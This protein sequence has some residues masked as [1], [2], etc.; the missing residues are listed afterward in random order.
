M[1]SM[2]VLVLG[3]ADGVPTVLVAVAG[4]SNGLGPTLA[5]HTPYPVINCPPIDAADA[6]HIDLW[7]SLR[8]PTGSPGVLVNRCH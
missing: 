2:A 6:N 5:G 8:M 3:S 1:I 4:L 7:S